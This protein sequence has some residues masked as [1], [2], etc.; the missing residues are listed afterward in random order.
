MAIT[1]VVVQALTGLFFVRYTIA[2]TR[3]SLP[4]RIRLSTLCTAIGVT[5][6]NIFVPLMAIVLTLNERYR[7]G[8]S[9][10]G[11]GGNSSNN[12]S[13]NSSTVDANTSRGTHYDGMT[14]RMICMSI[15]F[16]I[17][18]AIGEFALFPPLLPGLVHSHTCT[19]GCP[20][21]FI[22]QP[23]LF[24]SMCFKT[25]GFIPIFITS[26]GWVVC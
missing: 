21:F 23:F 8:G 22:L 16:G 9:G 4:L 26:W 5:L 6:F 18:G 13:S 20:F 14:L 12:S 11:N 1:N 19:F 17:H 10:D 7:L 25:F 3:A 2:F 24:W 15:N